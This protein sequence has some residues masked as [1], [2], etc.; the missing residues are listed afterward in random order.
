[1][2]GVLHTV[3]SIRTGLLTLSARDN[4]VHGVAAAP[5][6][7]RRTV[8]HRDTPFLRCLFAD[9]RDDLLVLPADSR[10]LIIDMQFSAQRRRQ[11]AEYPAARHD[12][13]VARDTPVGH[14][15]CDTDNATVRIVELAIS[16]GYRGT[17]VG[18]SVLAELTDEADL[19]C[20]TVRAQLWSANVGARRFF[21]RHGF[22]TGQ[23]VAGYTEV[24]RRPVGT[25][26]A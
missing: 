6:V 15:V 24:F 7:R 9:A 13:L 4:P 10:D 20:R 22:V 2:T 11:E 16:A 14:L 19:I 21:L 12:V 25:S 5:L 18:G 26:V 8:D 1:M 23:T 3:A 17:G